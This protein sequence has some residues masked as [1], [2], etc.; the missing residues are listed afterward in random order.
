MPGAKVPLWQAAQA[1]GVPCK[2]PLM[3]QLAHSTVIWLPVSGKPVL[4]WSK[5]VV[6]LSAGS[7]GEER[8]G[9]SADLQQNENGPQSA[10][11]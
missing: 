11:P 9:C 1:R 5:W 7:H 4:K 10:Q 2:R 3:W 8:H 6:P